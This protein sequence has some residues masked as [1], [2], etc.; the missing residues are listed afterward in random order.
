MIQDVSERA[1]SEQRLRMLASALE[2]R[3]LERTD[4]LE[5]QRAQLEA[6]VDQ[7]PV[8]LVIVDASS[9]RVL[10]MNDE[11]A[12]IMAAAGG[13]AEALALE[14][15][16]VKGEAVLGERLEIEHPEHGSFTL[17]VN[18]APVRDRS[19]RIVSAV[20]TIQDVTSAE[21]RERAEREF[22]TNAAHELQSPLAAITSA[23]EV[24]QAGAKDTEDRDLFLGHIDREAL[25]LGRVVRALLTLARTQT[26]VEGA[27]AELIV[28]CP[29]LEAIAERKKPAE[30]VELSV[31][32][33]TDLAVLANREL[34]EQ[35]ITNLLRNAVKYT[36][37]GSIRL[38]G[39]A[40]DGQVE[41]GVADTGIGIP[42]DSLPRVFD[43]FYKADPQHEG[44]GLGLSIVQ[45]SVGV[46]GGELEI[47]SSPGRGTTVTITLP[48]G[49]RVVRS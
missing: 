43:R 18:A 30:S 46:M 29:L 15:V 20:A 45:A 19:G 31:D 44:F 25:R 3:V 33:P 34:L 7:L 39:A 48:S 4:E 10:T 35:A 16:L 23:V 8:G 27:R 24:L 32:C 5:R 14:P 17:L 12:R 26:G 36:A 13:S 1:A 2:E 28:I 47:D 41:I 22:V 40:R 38:T 11:A 6:V 9:E 37:E 42:V 21:R 49:A